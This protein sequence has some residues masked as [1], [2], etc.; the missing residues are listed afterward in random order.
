[1]M[2]Q[3]IFNVDFDSCSEASSLPRMGESLGLICAGT[4][5]NAWH[6][7]TLLQGVTTNGLTGSTPVVGRQPSSSCDGKHEPSRL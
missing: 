6:A 2:F 7:R 5:G 3:D 4:A 1:M